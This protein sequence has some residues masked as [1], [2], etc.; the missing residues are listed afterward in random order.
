[1]PTYKLDLMVLEK[2]MSRLTESLKYYAE[3]KQKNEFALMQQFVQASIKH[4]I[5]IM[6]SVSNLS[7]VI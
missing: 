2:A 1:M 3:A 6:R 7:A 5:L 4:L